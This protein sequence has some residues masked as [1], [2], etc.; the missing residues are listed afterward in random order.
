MISDQG[1]QN[2]CESPKMKKLFRAKSFISGDILEK[3]VVDE[4][5]F[6]TTK[7]RNRLMLE[8][9]ARGGMRIGEVLKLTPNDINDRK[10]I[11]GDPKSGKESEVVFVPQKVADR[12]KDYFRQKAI[13]PY[14][15]IF[16]ICYEVA[17][18]MVKKAGEMVGV[19]LS[20]HGLWRFAPTYTRRCGIPVEIISK[21]IFRLA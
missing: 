17:R 9:M 12:L 13:Q 7:T 14:Q 8:L 5:I 16:H 2:A 11:I 15:R 3:E 4:T 1:F 21:V 10:L 6:G 19:R 18:A 20:P